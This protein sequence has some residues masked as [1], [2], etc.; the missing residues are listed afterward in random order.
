MNKISLTTLAIFTFLFSGISIFFTVPQNAIAAE[1]VNDTE[2]FLF[3]EKTYNENLYVGA[4]KT[5]I[6]S[7]VSE[8]L[9]VLGG[10]VTVSGNVAGDVL[11]VGGVV[12]FKGVVV[13]DLRIIGGEVEINGT[14]NGDVFVVGGNVL[15]SESAILNEDVFVVGGEASISNNSN[16]ELKVVAGNVRVDGQFDGS[17]EITTQSLSVGSGA[18]INGDL[19]YYAPQEFFAEDGSVVIGN[20]SFNEI[21]SLRDMG[22]VKKAI[23]SF[24]SFWY[25]LQF[26]TTLII[27]LGMVYVFRVFTK[28]VTDLALKSFWKSFLAGFVGMFLIMISIIILIA[29][30]FALPIG[31]LLMITMIFIV[32]ISPAISSIYIGTWVRKNVFKKTLDVDI[33]NHESI[34]NA[35]TAII[36]VITL[37]F[38]QIIP[39]IGEVV[40]LVLFVVAFGAIVRNIRLHIIK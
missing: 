6:E 29:S 27:A 9:V 2:V 32:I 15:I 24:M 21:N 40:K 1:I 23:L 20:I 4:G 13:G 26:I 35:K 18:R 19:S 5:I 31:F 39:V 36:G 17:T 28:E 33:E 12:D 14:V 16:T 37:T 34:I 7:N 11:L 30:I 25:L 3:A 38:L 8:D 22:L 10:D